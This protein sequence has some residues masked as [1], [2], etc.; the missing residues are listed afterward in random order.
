MFQRG[1][2]ISSVALGVKT[3]ASS[4]LYYQRPGNTIQPACATRLPVLKSQQALS[5]MTKCA[6]KTSTYYY[7]VFE[8][9]RAKQAAGACPGRKGAARGRSSS[10]LIKIHY[11]SA[12][13]AELRGGDGSRH[14][15]SVRSSKR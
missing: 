13:V 11:A 15:D 1:D 3:R 12:K 6:R 4:S 7:F 2:G 5:L 14:T 9:M 10:T 8:P